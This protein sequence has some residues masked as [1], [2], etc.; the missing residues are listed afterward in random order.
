MST[1]EPRSD[2]SLDASSQNANGRSDNGEVENGGDDDAEVNGRPPRWQ[3]VRNE[4]TNWPPLRIKDVAARAG[5]SRVH[6]SRVLNGRQ[7]PESS[8]KKGMPLAL[9]RIENAIR[10]LRSEQT[11]REKKD[12]PPHAEAGD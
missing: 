10:E 7:Q 1:S 11:G 8:G 3:R 12:A 5:L 9:D 4:L 2:D 6:V